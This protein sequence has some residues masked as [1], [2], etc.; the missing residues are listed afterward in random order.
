MCRNNKY[1]ISE[2]KRKLDQVTLFFKK[3][4][5]Q[6]FFMS[7]HYIQCLINKLREVD[8]QQLSQI[9]SKQQLLQQKKP[10]SSGKVGIDV[11]SFFPSHFRLSYSLDVT[12]LYLQKRTGDIITN[13]SMKALK[14]KE[15]E[16]PS[17]SPSDSSYLSQIRSQPGFTKCVCSL[18][19][20]DASV[21]FL[22]KSV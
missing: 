22:G 16:R 20:S 17:E 18:A 9:F 1:F 8:S 5:K 2:R 19:V 13:Q 4:G 21:N 3:L 12:L 6:F 15:R 11:S 14:A 10:V 7:T